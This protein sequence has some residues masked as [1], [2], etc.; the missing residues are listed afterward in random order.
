MAASLAASPWTRQPQSPF[1][2]HSHTQVLNVEDSI[3][4][5]GNFVDA[6]NLE[7]MVNAIKN[8]ASSGMVQGEVEFAAALEGADLTSLQEPDLGQ[9]G[10]SW[11]DFTA[12]RGAA[13]A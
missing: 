5:A 12:R 11:A 4:I 2:A 1:T 3:A 10:L 9:S 8:A 6:I 7:A 13:A